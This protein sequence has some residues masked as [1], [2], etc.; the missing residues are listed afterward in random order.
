MDTQRFARPPRGSGMGL[1][2]E[3][4]LC[5]LAAVGKQFS[6]QFS[7]AATWVF[8]QVE[9][10][11]T[12]T[13]SPPAP[14]Q[15]FQPSVSITASQVNTI[16]LW[17][18]WW[19]GKTP[20]EPKWRAGETEVAYCRTATVSSPPC[21][22]LVVDASAYL[23][24]TSRLQPTGWGDPASSLRNGHLFHPWKWPPNWWYIGGFCSW[25]TY[26]GYK[27]PTSCW[28]L[29]VVIAIDHFLPQP[30]WVLFS[31]SCWKVFSTFYG[32]GSRCKSFTAS[33]NVPRGRTNVW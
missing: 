9:R 2:L 24:F 11:F 27:R 33:C 23:E 26:K 19:E 6:R 13:A 31:S 28:K 30:A 16:I 1:L 12:V 18:L 32:V 14:S 20:S 15:H 17:Q 4:S 25:N 8:R 22:Y 5:S 10:A 29:P 7:T 3:A 21:W